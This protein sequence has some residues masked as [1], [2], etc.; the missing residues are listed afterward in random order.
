MRMSAILIIMLGILAVVGCQQEPTG[1]EPFDAHTK[2]A[3]LLKADLEHYNLLEN[4]HYELIEGTVTPGE[5]GLVSGTLQT[6]PKGCSF[7]LLVPPG[8]LDTQ[9]PTPVDFSVR[10]PTYESYMMH[11]HLNLPLILRL[12]PDG[13]E[14]H[15]TV[16][17]MATYMPW[18]KEAPVD[19]WH[20]APIIENGD[21]V[22]VEYRDV[23]R[24]EV[25]PVDAGWQVSFKVIHFSDWEVGELPD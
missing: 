6:W 17:V 8:A 9:D 14:F 19:F 22:D 1:L 4:L 12:E 25:R 7:G 16:T 5:G 24:V 23:G 15:D 13:M 10:V 3:T 20:V 18:E 11:D 2:N 21:V